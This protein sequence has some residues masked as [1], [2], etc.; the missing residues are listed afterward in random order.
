MKL[1]ILSSGILK[2]SFIRIEHIRLQ[3]GRLVNEERKR[4]T[5]CF[6]GWEPEGARE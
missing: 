5:H 3:K 4:V 6:S 2:Y 1:E